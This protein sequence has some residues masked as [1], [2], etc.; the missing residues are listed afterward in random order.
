MMSVHR[1]GDG[2]LAPFTS[3][4][5]GTAVSNADDVVTGQGIVVEQSIP[6]VFSNALVPGIGGGDDEA[7]PSTSSSSTDLVPHGITDLVLPASVARSPSSPTD[8]SSVITDSNARK[9][10]RGSGGGGRRKKRSSTAVAVAK[11][12][13][14]SQISRRIAK[15]V[16]T[17]LGM[18]QTGSNGGGRGGENGM[19]VDIINKVVAQDAADER[20]ARKGADGGSPK[21]P[22]TQADDLTPL[23]SGAFG[24]FFGMGFGTS[25]PAAISSPGG[26]GAAV[27]PQLKFDESGNIV[28]EQASQGLTGDV[29]GDLSI[30]TTTDES[31]R[32]EY[33][34]AYKRTARSLWTDKETDKFYEALSMYGPDLM[35]IST[36][37]GSTKTSSQLNTKLKNESKRNPLR[38]AA[39]CNSKKA[40]T[41][42]AFVKDHGPIEPPEDPTALITD[43]PIDPYAG[44][45]I[46]SNSAAT[47]APLPPAPLEDNP[48]LELLG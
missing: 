25:S 47:P 44:L 46:G 13:T 36:V 29:L 45:G 8:S 22:A 14:S 27:Q 31:G 1:G 39:A 9:P 16:R 19:M 43:H 20:K 12:L 24:D 23:D 17:E 38:F 40:I 10:R 3:T 18:E 7:S 41:T 4:N 5:R 30:M 37:F 28:L 11:P 2:S 15:R 42:D 33:K 26:G 21:T 48:L 32:C 6:D 35:M 34:D